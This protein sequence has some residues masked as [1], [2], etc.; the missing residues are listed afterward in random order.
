M[1]SS[2]DYITQYRSAAQAQQRKLCIYTVVSTGGMYWKTNITVRVNSPSLTRS[3]RVLLELEDHLWVS[4]RL[5][6]EQ[7]CLHS[8][9][10]YAGD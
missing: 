9:N 3:H 1:Q 10:E 8:Q 4:K 6:L 5:R 7:L 2:N